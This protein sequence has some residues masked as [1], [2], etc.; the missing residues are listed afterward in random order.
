[1]C[2]DVVDTKLLTQR[3][4]EWKPDPKTINKCKTS[5]KI[6]IVLFNLQKDYMERIKPEIDNVKNY[7]KQMHEKLLKEKIEKENLANLVEFQNK[8]NSDL[9]HTANPYAKE[10]T[11]DHCDDEDLKYKHLQSVSPQTGIIDDP[12]KTMMQNDRI[13]NGPSNTIN[14]FTNISKGN[15]YIN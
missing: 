6:G 15:S 7:D 5:T 4:R 2:P 14:N 10:F 13:L 1:M 11:K 9:A 3:Q 8:V 12:T